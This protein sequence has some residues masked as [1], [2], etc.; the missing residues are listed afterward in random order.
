MLLKRLINKPKQIDLLSYNRFA[1]G[2]YPVFGK[3]FYLKHI[4]N[5]NRSVYVQDFLTNCKKFNVVLF[6]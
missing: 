2:K 1:G 5:N 4:E 3:E 6:E